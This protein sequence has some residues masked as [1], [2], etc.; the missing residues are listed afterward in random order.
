MDIALE[1]LPK[2]IVSKTAK[3]FFD[4]VDEFDLDR[5]PEEPGI[6]VFGRQFGKRIE[7]I[8][9]G[10]GLNLRSRINQQFNNHKLLMAI[11]KSKTGPRVLL[12]A[13]VKTKRGQRLAKVIRIAERAH[14]DA[15]QTAGHPIVNVHGTRPK[16][17]SILIDGKKPHSHPFERTILLRDTGK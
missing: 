2:I 12:V 10:K 16:A 11:N 3:G 1:W 13:K 6:Y 14:I 15:A 8:Y 9:V 17:H 5:I 7:P 4:A